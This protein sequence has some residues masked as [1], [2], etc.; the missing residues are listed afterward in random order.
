MTQP[1]FGNHQMLAAQGSVN[2][3][4]ATP[5]LVTNS[6]N[7]Y[8]SQAI[9][10]GIPQESFSNSAAHE[11]FL[12]M[13][14]AVNRSLINYPT[15]DVA[16]GGIKIPN[17][18]AKAFQQMAKDLVT[19]N[20]KLTIAPVAQTSDLTCPATTASASVIATQRL[21]GCA[22]FIALFS[23]L[24]FVNAVRVF[25]EWAH[26]EKD[27]RTTAWQGAVTAT[28]TAMGFFGYEYYF[29]RAAIRARIDAGTQ[30]GRYAS[31]L[32]AQTDLDNS[33][34]LAEEGLQLV[35]AV[36]GLASTMSWY[37]GH[38]LEHVRSYDMPAAVINA[39]R[40]AAHQAANPAIP[41]P[42][43]FPLP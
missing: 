28:V 25:Q 30:T 39:E 33:L 31:T 34:A 38:S 4:T 37:T 35:N 5:D 21:P 15:S 10:W 16:Y 23:I 26:G 20:A 41:R 27:Y 13:F 36:A 24:H 32:I 12:Y 8:L 2:P 3:G 22:N 6:F 17:A 40:V 11:N 29:A 9:Y 14:D 42:I 1:I 7:N 19:P 43:T 18:V